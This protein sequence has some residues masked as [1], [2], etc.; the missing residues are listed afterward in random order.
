[1]KSVRESAPMDLSDCRCVQCGKPGLIIGEWSRRIEDRGRIDCL[2]CETS[3]EILDGIPY[4]MVLEEPDFVSLV[5]IAGEFDSTN[6]DP[7][8]ARVLDETWPRLLER[9][10]AT[11]EGDLAA[12]FEEI[13]VAN[14][15]QLED[16]YEQWREIWLLS[17][18]IDFTDKKVL[19]VGAGLGFDANLLLHRGADVTAIDLNPQT[20]A[21]GRAQ[22]PSAR[23]FGAVGRRLPFVDQTFDYVSISASLHH[24]LD[25]SATIV[26]ML[27]VLKVGGS[28]ITTN[29]SFSR[30]ATT[31]LEDA[32]MWNDHTAV[33]RGINENTP[34][35]QVF[36]DPVIE[37]A[38]DLDIEFWTSRA[39]G[40]WVEAQKSRMDF[41]MPRKW[42]LP[43][44][45]TRLRDSAGGL[46]MK[47]TPHKPISNTF[48]PPGPMIAKPS[49][50]KGFIGKKRLAMAEIAHLTPA[51]YLSPKFPARAG[52]TKFQV[53]NG[54]RWREETEVGREAYLLGRW[55]VHR[56]ARDK[57]LYLTIHTP[58]CENATDPL[59]TIAMDG[60]VLATKRVHRGEQTE[61]SVDISGIRHDVPVAIEVAMDPDSDKFEQGLF[62][63]ERLSFIETTN[64]RLTTGRTSGP[65]IDVLRSA[66]AQVPGSITDETLEIWK[67][68][69][70]QQQEWGQ[71]G[72]A[73]DI[74]P[75]LGR[76]T[77]VLLE[78]CDPAEKIIAFDY[79]DGV[80][81]S[82]KERAGARRIFIE[83]GGEGLRAAL[84]DAPVR[85]RSV[86]FIHAN[87]R[88]M[89]VV[90][91]DV[92]GHT[93][94]LMGVDGVLALNN[95]ENTLMPQV[96]AGAL[97][98]SFSKRS[99]LKPFLIAH[100]F[101]Y[102]CHARAH[103]RYLRFVSTKLFDRLI[104]PQN[105]MLS[106]SDSAQEF[107][108]F[109]ISP[110]ASDESFYG[111]AI[112][113]SFRK[114]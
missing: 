93:A 84:D 50:L 91:S 68:I 36:I 63:V 95:S 94:R 49:T 73:V 54:W 111:A 110:R 7:V 76:S 34:R 20:N 38:Q 31:D 1:M 2:H 99:D 22:T 39:F 56:A 43:H 78:L 109:R 81:A 53:L 13:G 72:D 67:E 26:E 44:D 28:L 33:L 75:A 97:H 114:A 101:A 61:L 8:K 30:D 52:N 25:V 100:N 51:P 96:W 79:D 103:G 105:L 55:W 60:N 71:S 92:I 58:V 107:D 17:R 66:S 46:F 86:R 80:V 69:F 29:D 24:V 83:A 98:A 62:R 45:N 85:E 108:V 77:Q 3:Y 41:L 82:V 32:R 21:F 9:R 59:L 18:E 106:R 40:V 6:Y 10:H 87:P 70:E 42:S 27:R 88:P 35:L 47:L 74:Q 23:W 37:R 112:Y 4:L 16:R 12:L 104:A 19:V 90:A 11:D 14:K 48:N 102:F 57:A 15:I 5:E 64:A 89:F 65:S 113:S